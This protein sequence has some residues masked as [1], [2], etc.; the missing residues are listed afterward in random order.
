MTLTQLLSDLY[1]RLDYV[2]APPAEIT[3]RLT[4]MLNQTHRQI[5]ST[6]GLESLRDDTITFASVSGQQRYG[7][8]PA[9]AQIQS[10]TDRTTSVRLSLISQDHLRSM[11]PGILS[12]GT[13]QA[14]VPIGQQAVALQPSAG[15]ELFVKS[16]SVS[17]TAIAYVEGIR[18]GGY[19]V[20]LSVTMTGT[21][22]VS[23]GAA[24]TDI[25]EVTKF[26]LASAAVGTI[27]L[28]ENSGIGTELARL[29]IGQTFSRYQGIQ[30]WPA[31]SS[32][33]TY[34]VD[35]MRVIPDLV[36]GTDQPLLP[37]DFHWL[38]VDGTLIQ[39]WTRKDDSRKADAFAAMSRGMGQLRYRVTCPP[40][41]LP[42]KRTGERE[43]SRLGG[44]FANGAGF[45]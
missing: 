39:E 28:R 35:Y 18:S 41:Y 33:L 13:P 2:S 17:D 7:L 4:A 21:T 16:T 25:V 44:N 6:P 42:S 31:P 40:D 15:S 27:T 30:L 11:D 5:L 43:L 23:L 9:I 19:P 1:R 24:Y 12:T 8:P 45:R 22:A 34:W 32:A 3:T 37:D 38:M 36:N 10:I 29:A 20:T 26:Y 14:Y